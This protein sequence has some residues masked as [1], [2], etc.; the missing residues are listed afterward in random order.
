[1]AGLKTS[2]RS[3]PMRLAWYIASS[4]SLRI[5]SFFGGSLSV[6]TSPIEAVNRISRSLKGIG[7]RSVRGIVS[8]KGPDRRI[9]AGEAQ[10]RLQPIEE[11]FAIGQPRQVVVHRV[12]QQ[13]LLGGLEFGD[14]SERADEA[15]DL[16]VGTDHR[17]RLQGE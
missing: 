14:V 1:M 17:P 13:A 5:S 8:A 2:M 10:R 7:A 15:H 16:A 6:S 11:Q 12:M 9:G 3:P 4:A